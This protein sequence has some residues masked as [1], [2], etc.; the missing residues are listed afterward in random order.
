MKSVLIYGGSGALGREVV[1]G[2]KK[3]NWDIYVVD[4][5]KN[6]EANRSILLQGGD[7]NQHQ[8][9]INEGIKTEDKFDC[10]INVAGGWVGGGILDEGLLQSID[11]MWN[12]NVQSSILCSQI[13]A[14][15]LREGGLLVL[16]G[17]SAGLG[18]TPSMLGYGI[19]KA[20]THH[21]IKSLSTND[22]GMP[23]NSTVVGIL[24]ITLDTKPNRESM[25]KA[26]FDNWT[27]LSF[28]S[29]LLVDWS[30][31]DDRP[32]N[33]SLIK[34]KTE[35]GKTELVFSKLYEN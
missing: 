11:K 5:Y 14:K 26:N 1:S 12:F 17:A 23:K 22:S 19:S 34:L 25:P 15:H 18:P 10:V 31:G 21:I 29:N 7:W 2:F 4:F 27:P 35:N 16:T 3:I 20:A 13:A 24:P 32:G 33:G 8:K 30:S 9:I 6:D 28:V